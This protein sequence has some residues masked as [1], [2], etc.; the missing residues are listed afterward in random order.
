MT[1]MMER[2]K[3]GRAKELRAKEEMMTTMEREREKGNLPINRPKSLRT[4]P[5]RNPPRGQP[6]NQ[7]RDLRRDPLKSQPERKEMT[8]MTTMMA[9]EKAKAKAKVSSMLTLI[10]GISFKPFT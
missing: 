3:G 6:G 10:D 8:T 9:K 5:P 1:M 4:S 7:P 2:A